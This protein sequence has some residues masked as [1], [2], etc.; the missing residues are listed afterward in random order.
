MSG[1]QFGCSGR[2]VPIADPRSQVVAADHRAGKQIVA[3]RSVREAVHVDPPALVTWKGQ[4]LAGT[5]QRVEADLEIR[6]AGRWKTSDAAHGGLRSFVEA[7]YQL[8]SIAC[9]RNIGQIPRRVSALC[10][11]GGKAY[12]YKAW[13]GYTWRRRLPRLSEPVASSPPI[14]QLLAGGPTN[15]AKALRLRIAPGPANAGT[16]EGISR[17]FH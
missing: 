2:G 15:A 10:A 13:V 6:G 16:T 1:G 7:V 5:K 3:A 14:Y 17:S 9:A 12:A 8:S 11:Y 4:R